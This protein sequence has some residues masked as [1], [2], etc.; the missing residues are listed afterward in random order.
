M[1]FQELYFLIQKTFDILIFVTAFIKVQLLQDATS[2]QYD[3]KITYPADVDKLVGAKF[4]KL[5]L[6]H[7]LAIYLNCRNKVIDIAVLANGL[8]SN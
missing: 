1:L 8:P 2:P 3:Y 6:E 4:R 7:L 5:V